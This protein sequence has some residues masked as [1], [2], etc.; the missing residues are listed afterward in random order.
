MARKKKKKSTRPKLRPKHKDAVT[1]AYELGQM[2]MAD[3]IYKQIRQ[4]CCN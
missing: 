1:A 2:D 3:K 4:G